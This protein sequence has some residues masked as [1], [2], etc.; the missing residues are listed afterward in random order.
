MSFHLEAP[1]Q[2]LLDCEATITSM[3]GETHELVYHVFKNNLGE[4]ERMRNLK[5]LDGAQKSNFSKLL[6]MRAWAFMH[7]V[8]KGDAFFI[9]VFLATNV[10]PQ[11]EIPSQYKDCN[12]VFEKKNVDI[13]PKHQ[14]CD[15]TIEF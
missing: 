15:Y 7:V 4:I 2:E 9:Y 5:N 10:G 8:K 6:F 11:H 13:L 3:V 14:P 12:D 1:K